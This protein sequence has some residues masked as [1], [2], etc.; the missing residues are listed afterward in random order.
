[1]YSD[2]NA[3][4]AAIRTYFTG[5]RQEM[6]VILALVVAALLATTVFYATTRDGFAKGLGAVVLLSS[7]L[8]SAT[9]VAL[10]RRD[11]PLRAALEA[12]VQSNNAGAVSSEAVRMA[13]V[14][15]RYA[16]Y[17]YGALLLGVLAFASAGV[18]RQGWV[19]GACAGALI[20]IAAQLTIDHYSE[21]RAVRYATA[22][23]TWLTGQ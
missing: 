18:T 8:L 2:A 5:E 16:F 13:E 7:L 1:M 9:A 6:L 3:L 4:N 15:R 20:L 14:I 23:R 12:A 21:R 22:L 10:L 11:P 17:R 19:H